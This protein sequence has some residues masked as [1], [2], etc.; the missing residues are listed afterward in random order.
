MTLKKFAVIPLM[1]GVLGFTIQ[2]VDQLL[3]PLMPTAIQPG[4]GF[5][6][7]AFQAWALY[8]L[9]GLNVQGAIKGFLGYA[10][11]IVASIAIMT[12]G[13][14]LMES[15]GFFA[16]PLAVFVVAFF[17]I[18]TERTPWFTSFI[19]AMFIGAGAYFA[20]M[21]YVPGATFSG[22]AITVL[23]YCLVGLIYGFVTVTLRTAYEKSLS[24]GKE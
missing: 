23:T 24:K 21:T 14:A 3:A 13:G 6:W 22:G 7:I 10:I 5:G 12:L 19:P 20:F 11:G 1:I 18:F 2:L 4:Q 15:L 17:L 9:A 8:F 16:F